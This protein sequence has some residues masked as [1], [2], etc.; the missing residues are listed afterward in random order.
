MEAKPIGQFAD[1]ATI[2]KGSQLCLSEASSIRNAKAEK[3]QQDE[4]KFARAL[5]DSNTRLH[6][7]DILKT[8]R[9]QIDSSSP[10]IAINTLLNSFFTLSFLSLYQSPF[11]L[12][13][14][15]S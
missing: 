13:P 6:P 9:E 8:P 5:K 1:G 3:V 10:G 15:T 14:S 11:Y 7:P 2:W 12:F 4:F